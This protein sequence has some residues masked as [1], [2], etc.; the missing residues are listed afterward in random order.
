M[1]RQ[2]APWVWDDGPGRVEI[3]KHARSFGGTRGLDDHLS[4]ALTTEGLAADELLPPKTGQGVEYG[5]DQQQHGGGHQTGRLDRGTAPLDEAHG[6]VDGRTHVVCRDAAD[7]RVESGRGRTYAQQ[8][9][10]LDEDDD[11]AR[12]SGRPGVSPARSRTRPT[13]MQMM[14]K[15]ITTRWKRKMLAMPTA[16]QRRMHS[17]PVLQGNLVSRGRDKQIR[18]DGAD[19]S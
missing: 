11:E 15:A 6:Q 1:E 9:R 3:E 17:T 12:A 8:K 14:L 19:A 10:H 13:H 4:D 2:E 5:G 16:K 18:S 7:E